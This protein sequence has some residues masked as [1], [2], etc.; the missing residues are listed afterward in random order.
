[1]GFNSGFKG[2]KLLKKGLA[3]FGRNKS[4]GPDG[5]PGEILKLGGEA[6]TLHLARLIEISFLKILRSQGTGKEPQWFLFTKGVIDR[7]SQTLDS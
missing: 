2:I 5:V 6:M 7:Q 4:V 3:K 1:M